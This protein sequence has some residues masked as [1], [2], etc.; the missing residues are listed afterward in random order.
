MKNVIDIPEQWEGC[1][2]RHLRKCISEGT[3]LTEVFE[4]IKAEIKNKYESIPDTFHDYE[5]G[6]T[7]ALEW[8]WCV[9]DNHISAEGGNE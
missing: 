8:V 5:T 3:P 1:T 2:N 9:I 6:F 4:V 7:D